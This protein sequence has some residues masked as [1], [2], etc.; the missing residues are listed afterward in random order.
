MKRK[1]RAAKGAAV[2]G[3]LVLLVGMLAAA[4]GPRH[5]L[6]GAKGAVIV[7]AL[8]QGLNLYMEFA[9]NYAALDQY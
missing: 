3:V 1:K 5:A 7:A 4:I 8:E 9:E 6:S 2:A